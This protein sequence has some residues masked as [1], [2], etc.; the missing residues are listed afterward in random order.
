MKK[1]LTV[2]VTAIMCALCALG[3]A[4]CKK[5]GEK[6]QVYVPDGAP[7]LALAPLM[8]GGY[9][10][11]EQEFGYSVVQATAIQA[12]VT[13]ESPKADLCV[14]PV[15][16]AVKILGNGEKYK[17]LG[18]VTHGNLFIMKKQGGEDISS[19][20]DLTKLVGKTV[21]VISLA[22]VPGLTFKVILRDAGLEFVD[23][24]DGAAAVADKVNLK[25]IDAQEALPS[26]SSCDYFVV[27]EPA[28]STKTSATGG[29]LSIAGSLQT[30]YGGD[31]GYPQAVLVAKNEI[32]EKSEKGV[33]AFME[34][35]EADTV[36]GEPE[37]ERWVNAINAHFSD[38]GKSSLNAQNLSQ[39]VVKNCGIRFERNASGKQKVIDFIQKLNA[40]SNASWGMPS[41]TFFF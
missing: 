29:K 40:V 25:N 6:W 15:N 26:N 17:M 24:K 12:Y 3:V 31:D 33:R 34:D 5:D 7:A 20:S 35:L 30:L 27:P 10:A 11:P 2:I 36:N 19:P 4:G 9:F 22:N 23:L 16:A 13:G 8:V 41:E 18:T 37:Y 21:G 39:T 1:F 28:A 32:I 38:G 14:L